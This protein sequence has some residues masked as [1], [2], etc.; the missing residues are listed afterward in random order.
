MI[1]KMCLRQLVRPEKPLPIRGVGDCTVCI[2]HPD[3][4]HCKIF[5]PIS[6]NVEILK[7]EEDA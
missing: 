7:D 5:Y 4:V 1:V 2:Q 3:N 6:I